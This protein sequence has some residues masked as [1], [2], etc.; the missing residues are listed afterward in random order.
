M[1]YLLLRRRDMPSVAGLPQALASHACLGMPRASGLL[2]AFKAMRVRFRAQ[3]EAGDLLATKLSILY[4][5][6]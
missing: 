6:A 3:I 2:W 1:C 5:T 4:P